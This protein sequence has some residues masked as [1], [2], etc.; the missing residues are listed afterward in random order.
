MISGR[1]CSITSSRAIAAVVGAFADAYH[2]PGLILQR[3]D[4]PRLVLQVQIAKAPLARRRRRQAGQI[5]RGGQQMTIGRV[6]LEAHFR[7]KV[8]L[9]YAHHHAAQRVVRQHGVARAARG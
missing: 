9:V 6:R 3:K 4:A 2:Q 5:R 1:L 7:L 8:A